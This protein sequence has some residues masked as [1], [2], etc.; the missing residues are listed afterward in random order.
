[1]IE[2]SMIFQT[3]SRNHHLG[4]FICAF[5]PSAFSN[6]FLVIFSVQCVQSLSFND[7]I[8]EF[9]GLVHGAKLNCLQ[10]LF[11]VACSPDS[12]SF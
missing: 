6:L 4:F 9:I 5:S 7:R 10:Q 3:K 11:F 12:V 2:P 8:F 1:M